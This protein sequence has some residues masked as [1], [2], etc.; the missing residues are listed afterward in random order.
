[1]SG[2]VDFANHELQLILDNC[3]EES[4]SLQTLINTNILN[5]VSLVASQGH[6]GFTASYLINTLNKLLR[7]QP[8]SS[9]TGNE[10]EWELVDEN[11]GLYQNIRCPS[12]FR[13]IEGKA[14]NVEGKVFTEDNGHTWFTCR[15]S[16]VDI[17]FP[18]NVPQYP[19]SVFLKVTERKQVLD[20]LKQLSNVSDLTEE[21]NI[22]QLFEVISRN[23]LINQIHSTYNVELDV[24]NCDYVWNLIT[25][26]LN[27]KEE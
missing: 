22:E 10:E 16:R 18:Y 20:K 1:M 7:Y 3:D 8:L 4:R 15:D 13:N 17:T 23:N 2:L 21:S 11:M 26:I 14:Y 24:N 9:L 27:D 19:E 12:V 25:Q 6:T 5:I